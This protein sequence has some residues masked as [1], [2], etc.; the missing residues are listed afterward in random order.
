MNKSKECI[1][2]CGSEAKKKKQ[3]Q[4]SPTLLAWPGTVF[5]QV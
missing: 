3:E 5:S 1:L 4:T 2:M